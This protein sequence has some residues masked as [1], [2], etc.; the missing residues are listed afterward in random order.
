MAT[1]SVSQVVTHI[2][3]VL[4]TD[5]ILSDICVKGEVSRV[6]RAASG[7]CYFALKDENSNLE[8]VI[9]RGS[10]GQEYILQGDEIL[11]YGRVTVY[12]RQGRL[13]LVANLVQPSGVGELQ[14]R[15]EQMKAILEAEG[16]FDSSR[17]RSLPEY[18]T[19]VG[20]V[21][22]QDSAA[23]Q[24][25]Q[26][27]AK[28]RFPV[29]ELIIC[30]SL[31]QGEQAPSMIADSISRLCEIP[32]IQAI[33]VARGGGSPEDL[34][35][36]NEEVVARAIF[37]SHI[38][39]VSGVG[40][41]NDWT[42]SDLVADI[43]ASTPTGAV[44]EVFPDSAEIREKVHVMRKSLDSVI[45]NKFET[46][47]SVIDD[48][49]HSISS[50]MPD[51]GV[52]KARIRQH[53]NQSNIYIDQIMDNHEIQVG[54]LKS[55]LDFVGPVSTLNRGYSILTKNTG[56]IVDSVLKVDIGQGIE[57][58]VSDGSLITTVDEVIESGREL[59]EEDR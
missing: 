39:V 22:S 34:W 21:T 46:V 55:N 2:E 3:G 37:A 28:I 13:Q 45:R 56:D 49:V 32:Y 1:L 5:T 42:I 52:Q 54:N 7:H 6:T 26:K 29:A 16:L 23:W 58:T 31:V 44:V 33:V 57:V 25:I 50:K 17:K 4:D 51:I 18:P 43:R 41:E 48:I 24:D 27:T 59:K 14:A 15:F 11:A 40:H 38:P 36:F 19:C 12:S 35:A 53:I 20:V 10:I 47:S 8:A 9:F 30:H